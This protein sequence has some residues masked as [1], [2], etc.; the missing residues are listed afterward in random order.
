MAVLY[1]LFLHKSFS[2]G[3]F[4]WPWNFIEILYV[5]F[6]LRCGSSNLI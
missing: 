4:G 3:S 6:Y 2:Y 1:S 5:Y